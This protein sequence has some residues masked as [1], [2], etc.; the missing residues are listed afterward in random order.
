MPSP[1]SRL[2]ANDCALLIV[3]AGFGRRNAQ[4]SPIVYPEIIVAAIFIIENQHTRTPRNPGVACFTRV[5][6]DVNTAAV[7]KFAAQLKQESVALG[8]ALHLTGNFLI[9]IATQEIHL[10]ESG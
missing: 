2:Y 1:K 7:L 4:L 9:E 5:V 3:S 10:L 6:A 8:A